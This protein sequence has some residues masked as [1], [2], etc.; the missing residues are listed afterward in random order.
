M[1]VTAHPP[2][3]A[4][5]LAIRLAGTG[6]VQQKNRETA[7]E[8]NPISW[9]AEEPG[10]QLKTHE[11]SMTTNPRGLQFAATGLVLPAFVV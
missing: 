9:T 8:G 6:G 10:P 5:Y 7:S 4:S 3:V 1:G 11:A 2:V